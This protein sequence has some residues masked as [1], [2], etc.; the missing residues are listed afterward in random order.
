MA[1]EAFYEV[2]QKVDFWVVVVVEVGEGAVLRDGQYDFVVKQVV[3]EII[4][5]AVPKAGD[6]QEEEMKIDL[7]T[8]PNAADYQA[9]HEDIV[10]MMK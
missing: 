5:G 8:V 9:I 7:Q 10:A 6:Y 3:V 1:V 2:A 4:E